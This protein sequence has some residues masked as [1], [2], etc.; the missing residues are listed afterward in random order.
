MEKFKYASIAQFTGTPT[1][2][3]LV[4]L[5]NEK[6][7]DTL[8][9]MMMLDLDNPEQKKAFETKRNELKAFES[10]MLE[11]KNIKNIYDYMEDDENK[12]DNEES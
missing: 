3:Y 4:E 11:I 12:L 2:E 7:N 1:F 10:F 8:T 9:E 6:R 5:F